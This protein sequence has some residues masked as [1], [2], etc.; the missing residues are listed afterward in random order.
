MFDSLKTRKRLLEVEEEC[1]TLKRE[2]TRLQVEW[3][4]TLD[5]LKSMIG[6][7]SKERARAEAARESSPEQMELRDEDVAAG[8][9]SLSQRQETINAQIL[10]RRNR[11]RAQ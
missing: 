4:D 8:H 10:A 9:T 6:R 7:L 11:T 5:R 2:L 3:Q 1:S